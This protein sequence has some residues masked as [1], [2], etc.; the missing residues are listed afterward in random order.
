MRTPASVT[1]VPFMSEGWITAREAAQVLGVHLSAI[2]KMIRRG[3][4]CRR[5]RR[6]ILRR[7]DVEAYRDARLAAHQALTETRDLPPRNPTSPKPPDG[8]HDWLLADEAADV[9]GI[10]PV[11]INARARRGRLPSVVTSGR[12]WYRRDHLEL[13]RHALEAKRQRMP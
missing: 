8:E 3:D 5:D 1:T 10:S 11:A 6:P 7:A 2:P 12:R 9:M 13:V 4:L